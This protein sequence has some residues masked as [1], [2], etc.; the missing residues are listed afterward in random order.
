[1]HKWKLTLKNEK[2]EIVDSYE[3]IIDSKLSPKEVAQLMVRE[4]EQYYKEQYDGYRWD[5]AE[6]ESHEFKARIEKV[7]TFEIYD[8]DAE[9]NVWVEVE[10]ES[11]IDDFAPASEEEIDK[12]KEQIFL[13]NPDQIHLEELIGDDYKT[14]EERT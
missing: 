6:A 8:F 11:I 7:G 10:A 3:S 9:I 2:G 5:W 14:Y 4:E 13:N 12:I 1:M